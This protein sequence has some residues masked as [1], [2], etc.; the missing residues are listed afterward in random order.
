MKNKDRND[1]GQFIKG[2]RPSKNTEFQ[3]GQH[4][5]EPQPY[6]NKDVLEDLYIKQQKSATEIADMFECKS[7]NILYFL[8]KNGIPRR[9]IKETREIKYWGQS[10]EDNPMF[11]V[12]GKDNPNWQGGH[13]PFRQRMYQNPQWKELYKMV[14]ERD[15]YKCKL[16]KNT[17]KLHLHH[18]LPVCLYPELILEPEYIITVCSECHKKLHKTR[19][20]R[21]DTIEEFNQLFYD[22]KIK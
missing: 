1:K 13:T 22:G 17:K 14:L 12:T 19:Y 4:W 11:G 5:R 7:A 20:L 6:W 16:C 21:A 8:K 9:S 10:G 2:K 3:K 18:T 15:G